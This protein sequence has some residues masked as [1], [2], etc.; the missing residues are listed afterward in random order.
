MAALAHI[1]IH[2]VGG[3]PYVEVPD[4]VFYVFEKYCVSVLVAA[5]VP[6]GIG[7]EILYA[8]GGE[9]MIGIPG[10]GTDEADDAA[11]EGYE[12]Q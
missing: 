7:D 8:G 11:D 2:I 6:S 3:A 5:C 9:E 1:L 10:V 4:A 12:R